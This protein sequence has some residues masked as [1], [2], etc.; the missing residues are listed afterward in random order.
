MTIP[1]SFLLHCEQTRSPLSNNVPS[2]TNQCCASGLGRMDRRHLLKHSLALGGLV[3]MTTARAKS[4]GAQPARVPLMEYL[5]SR[6]P[7]HQV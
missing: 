6:Y 7:A 1:S 3:R 4:A 5:Y 2:D